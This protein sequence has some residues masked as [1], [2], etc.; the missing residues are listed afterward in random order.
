MDLSD[1]TFADLIVL[2][3]IGGGHSPG[4]EGDYVSLAMRPSTNVLAPV[5]CARNGT[6]AAR[7]GYVRRPSDHGNRESFE[8]GAVA[9]EAVA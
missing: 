6:S 8:S 2:R 5:A 3:L 9:V 1:D 7:A 4:P